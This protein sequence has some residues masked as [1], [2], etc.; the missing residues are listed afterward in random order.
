VSINKGYI[1]SVTSAGHNGRRTPQIRIDK[2]NR[3][4]IDTKRKGGGK[5][6]G[7]TNETL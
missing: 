5:S 4:G 7:F 6:M 2:F 1:I 3:R